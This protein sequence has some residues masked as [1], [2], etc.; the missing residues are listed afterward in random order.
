VLIIVS[1]IILFAEKKQTV[2]YLTDF[3][4]ITHDSESFL[5]FS[6]KRHMR[7]ESSYIYQLDYAGNLLMT[8]EVKDEKFT[9]FRSMQN[10]NYPNIISLQQLGTILRTELVD[11]DVT[12]NAF[13][14]YDLPYKHETSGV[15][16]PQ[17]FG[18]KRFFSTVASHVDGLQFHLAEGEG[19]PIDG[20]PI[21]STCGVKEQKCI[22]NNKDSYA[23][24]KGVVS[25]ENDNFLTM[26]NKNSANGYDIV[27]DL[28]DNEYNHRK[29]KIIEDLNINVGFELFFVDNQVIILPTMKLDDDVADYYYIVTEELVVEKYP[30]TASL[31]IDFTD[32]VY[33][34]KNENSFLLVTNRVMD[35]KK[36]RTLTSVTINGTDIVINDVAHLYN[37]QQ[38]DELKL[39]FIDYLNNKIYLEKNN[40]ETD[41][42][43]ILIINSQNEEEYTSISLPD[44]VKAR[45]YIS[46]VATVHEPIN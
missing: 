4:P 11:Y 14:T 43:E 9:S 32:T 24:N 45:D 34:Q 23:V 25:F 31:S 26:R 17:F 42:R 5:I 3:H 44:K 35:E 13:Q 33:I 19:I 21:N 1:W 16:S 12:N 27:L 18:T 41:E 38:N 10:I 22:E 30:F 6:P 2:N 20:N 8:F 29:T 39:Y 15:A 37:L 7:A 46:G 28:Y 36:G 40:A